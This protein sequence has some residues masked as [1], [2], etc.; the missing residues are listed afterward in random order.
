MKSIGDVRLPPSEVA[1]LFSRY[2]SDFHPYLPL[3]DDEKQPDDYFKECQMLYWVILFV[4]SRRD[5]E[6]SEMMKNLKQP[7]M[8]LVYTTLSQNSQ[9]YNIVKGLCL[10]C[11]WPPYTSSTSTDPTFDLAGIMMA[12]A[13]R[14]GLHRPSHTRDFARSNL[15]VPPAEVEDRLRTW[16]ACNVVAQSV[17]TGYGQPSLA[18]FDYILKPEDSSNE[19]TYPLPSEFRVRLAMEILVKRISTFLYRVPT[20]DDNSHQ[21]NNRHNL[22]RIFDAELRRLLVDYSD[23]MTD[24]DLVYF[25]AANLHLHLSAFFAPPTAEDY[26]LNLR[27][28]YNAASNFID[29]AGT[30]P[31]SDAPNYIMQMLLAAGFTIL[32]LLNGFFAH[33]MD[34]KRARSALAICVRSV[35][36]ISVASNDLP[37]R[38]AEVLAQMSKASPV[39]KRFSL[40]LSS[41]SAHSADATRLD[42]DPGIPA[43]VDD[44]LKL[45]VKYRRSMSI[46]YD[47]VWSWREMF[48][49][50]GASGNLDEAVRRPTDP[51][52]GVHTPV[53]LM[54]APQQQGEEMDLFSGFEGFEDFGAFD[55]TFDPLVGLPD[56]V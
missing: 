3:L 11:T 14:L 6:N 22:V 2:W 54:G 55:Q 52:S 37:C 53:P 41:P 38:L 56:V 50:K 51:E 16:A 19:E 17:S 39:I 24:F 31:L 28:L 44:S 36:D 15:V 42:L 8:Q 46:V 12:M 10:I 25:K 26:I 21:E 4:A 18:R 48:Q 7:V 5:E 1:E 23:A 30:V 20:S 27:D 34:T 45:L 29:Q 35:R 43:A 13:M 32:R 47:S 33:Y 9:S 49:G 40:S